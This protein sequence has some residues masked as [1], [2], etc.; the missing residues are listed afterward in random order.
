MELP[1]KKKINVEAAEKI[2]RTA[3]K[4]PTATEEKKSTVISLKLPKEL[5]ERCD[6]A[7]KSKS[8]TRSAFIKIAITNALE[9]G[10]T[11]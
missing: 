4:E 7:A 5:L 10:V 1:K 9:K 6:K 8:I 3:V 2:V 11:L